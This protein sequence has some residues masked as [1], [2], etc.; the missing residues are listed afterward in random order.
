[1]EITFKDLQDFVLQW[2]NDK[3]ILVPENSHKQALKMVSEVGE[4]CDAVIKNDRFEQRD[5]IGDVL[6]TVIILAEQLG[7]NPVKCLDIAYNVIRNRKGETVN[8]VFIKE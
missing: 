1:M 4:L 6:V 8:G 2:A 7:H 3:G 5:A